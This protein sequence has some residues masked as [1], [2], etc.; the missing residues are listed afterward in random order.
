MSICLWDKERDGFMKKVERATP[1][2]F[3]EEPTPVICLHKDVPMAM[4]GSN[5]TDQAH[6]RHSLSVVACGPGARAIPR[7]PPAGTLSEAL[8]ATPR[9][10]HHQNPLASAPLENAPAGIAVT[11][12]GLTPSRLHGLLA[13]APPAAPALPPPLPRRLGPDRKR[14]NLIRIAVA[15]GGRARAR[16]PGPP[17]P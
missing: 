9:S 4:G 12:T 11:A 5:S 3:F 16:P 2:I 8:E 15:H 7:A 14:A 1:V 6:H 10:H 13:R 17:P